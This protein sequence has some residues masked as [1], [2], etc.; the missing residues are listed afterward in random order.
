LG[1]E[2]QDNMSTDEMLEESGTNWK[3]F[4]KP[5]YANMGNKKK[6][7]M[8]DDR[9]ALIRDRDEKILDI[10]GKDW[11][12]LQNHQAFDFFREFVEAGHMTM[13]TAGSLQ[14]GKRVWVLAKTNDSFE[15]VK[16][17]V[18]DKYFLFSNPHEYGKCIDIRVTPI[19]VVCMNTLTMALARSHDVMAR[20]NHC[21]V[22][23]PEEAKRILGIATEKTEAY[24]GAAK[25]LAKK[26]ATDVAIV[27]YLNSVFPSNKKGS[28]SRTA[29]QAQKIIQ[30]QPGSEFAEGSWWQAFNAITFMT[31][32]LLGRGEDTRL[33][34]AWYGGNARKKEGALRKALELAEN[35]PDLKI[36]A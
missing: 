34:S 31:D 22:F 10:V 35:S 18:V 13:E 1:K 9:M 24:E 29:T 3:V 25:L 14:G 27:E 16:G 28:L 8:I 15:V 6:Q 23:N 2:V 7:I 19:R 33:T 12:P 21:N 36:A 5:I 4:K 11:N 32:H 30:S 17:D 26:R 20:I